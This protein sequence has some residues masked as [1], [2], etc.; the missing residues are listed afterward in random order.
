[1]VIAIEGRDARSETER[2]RTDA[3]QEKEARKEGGPAGDKE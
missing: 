1:M 3:E 2:E